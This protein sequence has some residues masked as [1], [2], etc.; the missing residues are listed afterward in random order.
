[1]PMEM[2]I[3]SRSNYGEAGLHKNKRRRSAK[4]HAINDD[5]PVK[6]SNRKDSTC[7]ANPVFNEFLILN[8][9]S[10]GTEDGQKPRS[11][12]NAR[13]R[14]RTHSVN[15]AFTALRTLIPTEPADRKLS[16][17]ETLRLASSYIAHL[18]TQLVAGPMDQPCLKHNLPTPGYDSTNPRPVCTFCLAS[19]KKMQK[20]L[21]GFCYREASQP[22]NIDPSSIIHELPNI[23][24]TP[25]SDPFEH[26]LNLLFY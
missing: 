4:S 19:M 17:I 15:S 12:A 5:P 2:D 14:D 20:S 8:S 24:S 1:M 11:H 16:K 25:S 22:S 3:M 23:I 26:N 7:S 9:S 18:G 13:E 6:K 10:P 21:D